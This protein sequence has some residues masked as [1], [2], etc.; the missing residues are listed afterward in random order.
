[1]TMAMTTRTL[2]TCYEQ[3]AT[4]VSVVSVVVTAVSVV[5]ENNDE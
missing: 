5:V 4:V 2:P 3:I 1:M